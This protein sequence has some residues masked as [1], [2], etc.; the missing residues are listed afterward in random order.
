MWKALLDRALRRLIVTGS[1]GIT[2]PDKTTTVYG[3]TNKITP[4]PVIQ[5]RIHD[6]DLPRRLIFSPD[7]ALG[8]A[9][10]DGHLTLKNDDLDGLL[11]LLL[12]NRQLGHTTLLMDA[13]RRISNP[14]QHTLARNPL[15]KSRENAAHHYNLSSKLYDLFLDSDR[16]YSCAYF[17]DPEMSLD[18]A[19]EA[20]KH[21]IAR[22]LCIRPGD[23]ILDIGC[24]WGGMALTLAKDYGVRVVGI[25][26]SDEQHRIALA[27]VDAAGLSDRI[28]IRLQDYRDVQGPYERIVSV[29][30]LEH[31]GAPH[32]QDYF[33]KVRDLLTSDGVALIHT[34][35]TATPPRATS[36]WIRANIFPGGYLPA[37]SEIQRAVEGNR[38]CTTDVEVLRFHYAY[39]L[40][41][42]RKRFEAQTNEVRT[43]YDDRFVRMW[44]YYLTASERSFIDERLVVF[45]F[46]LASDKKNVPL[47]RDYLYPDTQ[48]CEVAERLY[49]GRFHVQGERQLESV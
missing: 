48:K 28:E 36:A 21:H 31:V 14:L 41:H 44:R 11:A 33:A 38:L 26:L 5:A 30:M 19:Q 24:G 49:P 43:L 12:R 13:V 23:R 10:T 18:A 16:Q 42:W 27:R 35:G 1:L 40:H 45:Q 34:I 4:D 47:T 7:K 39:T 25:T 29:G 9:Y 17:S 37:M 15:R 46:Q 2:W 22:K 8:D 32:F 6:P 20:K 3:K